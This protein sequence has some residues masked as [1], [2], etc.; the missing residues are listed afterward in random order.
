MDEVEGHEHDEPDE[1]A[2]DM[3]DAQPAAAKPASSPLP[4]IVVG[5]IGGAILVAVVL[6]IASAVGHK[7]SSTNGGGAKAVLPG[8][9]RSDRE[10]LADLRKATL[11]AD[12]VQVLSKP[13]LKPGWKLYEQRTEVARSSTSTCLPSLRRPE[14]GDYR[15]WLFHRPDGGV[16]G[17]AEV[18]ISHYA[19]AETA[20]AAV[21]GRST[22]TFLTCYDNQLVK[23]LAEETDTPLGSAYDDGG[24]YVPGPKTGTDLVTIGV[25]QPLKS[26]GSGKGCTLHTYVSWQQVVDDV[27]AMTFT[28]CGTPFSYQ[29]V[30]ALRA[31][32][33]QRLD[34]SR[35]VGLGPVGIGVPSEEPD[36]GASMPTVGGIAK[37]YLALHAAGRP[38][39]GQVTD[40]SDDGSVVTVDV[41]GDA[42]VTA[43]DL[44]N[45]KELCELTSK[46]VYDSPDRAARS[47][48][49]E[50]V[51]GKDRKVKGL[52]TRLGAAATCKADS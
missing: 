17:T 14:F 43:A 32:V 4:V 48:H 21:T 18:R 11:R 22:P 30:D 41:Q 2:G 19:S 26:S 40:T 37:T 8:Q 1:T 13:G 36:G 27:V 42:K 38:W 33:L 35:P 47:V 24:T 7:G 20:R 51:S 6:V 25:E 45:A 34:G 31:T 16:A 15:R 10:T 5:V 23:D 49:V 12:D 3:P 46:V 39:D 29:Q 28:T 9:A 44:A 50:Q 52:V